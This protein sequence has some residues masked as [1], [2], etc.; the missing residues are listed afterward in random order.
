MKFHEFKFFFFFFFP[1]LQNGTTPLYISS[2]EGH[3]EVVK[4][5][6]K[7]KANI[8]APT[9][10]SE[11]FVFILPTVFCLIYLYKTSFSLSPSS[12]VTLFVFIFFFFFFHSSNHFFCNFYSISFF[13]FLRTEQPPYM[14]LL[15]KAILKW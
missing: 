9:K 10:V 13:L 7:G 11:I 12:Q 5:L 14:F 1:F 8:E 6:I 4:E 2:Q 3:V 15:R